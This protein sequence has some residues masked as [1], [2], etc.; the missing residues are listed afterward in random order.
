MKT[1]NNKIVALIVAAGAGER[2]G[3]RSPKQYLPLM[4]RPV[5]CRSV[6]AFQNHPMV[7]GCHV[8][9]HPDHQSLFSDATKS[10]TLP[11]PVTGGSNRQESVRKGLEALRADKPDIVLIHD[12]ARP[13]VSEDLI[14][15]LCREAT[16]SGAAIPGIPVTDTVRR[17]IQEGLRTE[18]R[19]G[20]YTVQTPQAFRFDLID[21]LHQK[22]REQS[23]TDDAALCEADRHS[24]AIVPGQ[25]DN[26]KITHPEDLMLAEQYLFSRRGDVRT[27][28]GY[29]VHR[30]IAPAT[31]ERKLMLC[32]VAVPH[33]KV[34]EG[35][36]DADVGLH[37][38]TDAV[39]ATIC[40]G[41]IGRHFSPKDMRWKN[42]DSTLFLKHAAELVLRQGGMITH[43]DVTLIC[44]APHISPHRDA[45]RQRIAEILGLPVRRISV[46]ATTTEGL[47]FTGR[48]EGIAAQAVV[49]AHLPPRCIINEKD[50]EKWAH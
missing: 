43:V 1:K 27:G 37:A 24:V 17:R 8:V 46:K 34:L 16:A 4:G 18:S 12:A 38:V 29:D 23:F 5:L 22:Y 49:T 10:L 9:I 15:A 36:S 25:R 13:L 7:S 41:D 28:Q 26:I 50:T 44:E 20:L 11:P 30:L 32:G 21:G 6:A 2:F 45:M 14:S 31:P 39:L 19:E 47:G 42:A 40:D 3:G 33:D 35:H 48:R